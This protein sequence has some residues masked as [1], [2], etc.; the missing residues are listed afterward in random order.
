[1]SHLI[2]D[3][4]KAH[5]NHGEIFLGHKI[6]QLKDFIVVNAYHIQE[7]KEAH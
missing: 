6:N 1:M 3:L 2:W 7:K 5:K 4:E